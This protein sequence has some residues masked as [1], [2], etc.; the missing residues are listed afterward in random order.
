VPEADIP[1]NDNRGEVTEDLTGWALPIFDREGRRLH[2]QLRTVR[3]SSLSA[4][5]AV[6]RHASNT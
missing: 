5:Q 6:D 1:W 4:G 3:Q 2:R